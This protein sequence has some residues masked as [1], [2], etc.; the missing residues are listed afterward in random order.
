[1]RSLFLVGAVLALSSVAFADRPL[2]TE[3]PDTVAVGTVEVE[4]GVTLSRNG[5]VKTRS[6]GEL[7]VSTGVSDKLEVSAGTNYVDVK[8]GASGL[9]DAGAAVKYRF[10]RN[11][12]VIVGTSLPTGNNAFTSN[13]QP[14]ATLALKGV[15]GRT[16]LLG[17]VGVQRT[18]SG[19]RS[20]TLFG[21]LAAVRNTSLG[22]VSLEVAGNADKDL[23]ETSTVALGLQRDI[24]NNA[25]F[26]VRVGRGLSSNFGE[27][28]YFVGAGLTFRR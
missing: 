8:N 16:T 17:N 11:A 10:R 4:T 9:T 18:D 13:Y 14:R 28:N 22:R 24:S 15:T 26:D 21:S 12:A 3:T 2:V 27:P 6:L 20:N 1:V 19:V 7:V 5:A 23:A 25:S